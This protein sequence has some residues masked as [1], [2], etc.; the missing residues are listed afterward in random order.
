VGNPIPVVL[1][2]FSLLPSRASFRGI[3]QWTDRRTDGKAGRQAG[4]QGCRHAN[5]QRG[6]QVDGSRKLLLIVC[7]CVNTR[8]GGTSNGQNI[9]TKHIVANFVFHKALAPPSPHIQCWKSSGAA[10]RKKIK[11]R[12]RRMS[13]PVVPIR[14]PTLNAGGWGGASERLQYFVL[15]VSIAYTKS[16]NGDIFGRKDGNKVVKQ[17]LC[18]SARGWRYRHYFQTREGMRCPIYVGSLKMPPPP[19]RKCFRGSLLRGSSSTTL[20]PKRERMRC[21]LLRRSINN[22]NDFGQCF[23]VQG[24]RVPDEIEGCLC[25]I[26]PV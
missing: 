6:R 16:I 4:R 10:G 19:K 22:G 17:T 12:R 1:P 26:N 13:A 11:V 21:G 5:R 7:P 25:P 23:R 14:F 3:R 20:P 18:W 24:A 9:A 8:A 2:L 15:L